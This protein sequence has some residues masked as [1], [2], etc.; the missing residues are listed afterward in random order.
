MAR[1][2]PTKEWVVYVL[3]GKRGER[4]G[5][6][7]APDRDAAIVK[8]IEFFGITDPERQRRVIARPIAEEGDIGGA[9]S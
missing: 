9:L 3:T 2:T 1:R 8:A 7:T 4:L 5:T 6:V